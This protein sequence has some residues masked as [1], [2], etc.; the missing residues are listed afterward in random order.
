MFNQTNK[1][2]NLNDKEYKLYAKQIILENI[3]INGQQKLKNAKI[4]LIGLGG[5]GCPALIYLISSGIGSIGIIDHDRINLSNLNRQIL[6]NINDIYNYKTQLAQSAIQKINPQCN[7]EA[8]NEKLNILNATNIIKKYDIII[9]ATDNFKTRYII[10]EI[11]YKLHKIHI[12]GAINKY[13]GHVSVLNYKNNLRY[14]DIY[15]KILK[16]KNINCEDH[17]I[18]GTMSGIVGILQA[19]ESIKIILGI[20]KIING[21]LLKYNLLDA[22]FQYIKFNP[23]KNKNKDSNKQISKN[24]QDN[25]IKDNNLINTL[26]SKYIILD[27]RNNHDFKISHKYQTINIPADRFK[28]K[29]TIEFLKSYCSQYQIIIT[30][31]Q[32]IKSSTISQLL[33]RYQIQTK[34]LNKQ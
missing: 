3:G 15:P 9:D 26:S 34:V 21:Y 33:S 28:A 25:F 5:L 1:L 14:I 6:Y 10:D 2:I 8:Y 12:Y 24:S 30:C 23:D 18:L 16:L 17:G 31:N 27:I 32:F 29:E 19:T 7:I 11:C 4:L 22:S 20:G 13:E